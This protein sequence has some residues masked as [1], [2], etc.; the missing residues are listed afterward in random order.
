M[1]VEMVDFVIG[2]SNTRKFLQ[3]ERKKYFS[4]HK[5]RANRLMT[6]EM[7][8]WCFWD[9][10]LPFRGLFPD[11]AIEKRNVDMYQTKKGNLDH[12]ILR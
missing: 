1:T 8:E 2:I 10:E 11:P 4:K 6:V 3:T 9:R 7:L 12:D 5:Y